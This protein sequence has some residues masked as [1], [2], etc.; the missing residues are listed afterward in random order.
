MIRLSSSKIDKYE[1]PKGKET[2]P[3]SRSQVI[4]KSKFTYSLLGKALEKQTEK[5][6]D[7]LPS[8][9]LSAKTDDLKQIE[10]I[11]PKNLLTNVINDRAK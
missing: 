3:F 9:N 1:Y 11:F 8:L 5:Q 10:N 4:E 7:A 6:V 2:T